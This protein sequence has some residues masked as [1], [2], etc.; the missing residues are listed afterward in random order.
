MPDIVTFLIV[1]Y[2]IFLFSNLSLHDFYPTPR[3]WDTFSPIDPEASAETSSFFDAITFGSMGHFLCGLTGRQL[4]RLAD[5]GE[6]T[7]PTF[8]AVFGKL[9]TCPAQ[10]PMDFFAEQV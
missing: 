1:Q 4:R 2:S 10:E 3:F 6:R 9:S 7:V 5:G 8:L